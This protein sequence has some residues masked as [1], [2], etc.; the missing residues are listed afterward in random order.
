MDSPSDRPLT[1]QL[2]LPICLLKCLF[3]HPILKTNMN[4]GLELGLQAIEVLT[5]FFNRLSLQQALLLE[6][7]ALPS[8]LIHLFPLSLLLNP[9]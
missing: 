3:G 9:V 6:N 7:D 1:G 8:L 4:I 2:F 5:D